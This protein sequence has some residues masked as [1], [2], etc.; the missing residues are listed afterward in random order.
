MAER[1][2]NAGEFDVEMDE[3]GKPDIDHGNYHDAGRV[4]ESL[5]SIS[6]PTASSAPLTAPL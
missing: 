1:Y 2:D 6:A 4:A 3:V 5:V